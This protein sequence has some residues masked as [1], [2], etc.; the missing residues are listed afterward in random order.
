MHNSVRIAVDSARDQDP[1]R[2]E[3][4]GGC[5]DAC[6]QYLRTAQVPVCAARARVQR[7]CMHAPHSRRAHLAGGHWTPLCQG[8]HHD[9]LEAARA[10][11]CCTA[12]P[13]PCRLEPDVE[14]QSSY[15]SQSLALDSLS[16]DADSGA[17]A[18]ELRRGFV[19]TSTKFQKRQCAPLHARTRGRKV[20]RASS[21]NHA[22]VVVGLVLLGLTSP[23]YS[24]PALSVVR[25][26]EQ[27]TCF[28]PLQ[29]A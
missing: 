14:K 22:R 15:V 20:N 21:V 8:A 3:V 9:G 19:P 26:S 2:E 27:C 11:T 24:Y 23:W 5:A 16:S 29:S 13:L 17:H 18:C 6:T 4:S 25:S 7:A 1:M 28:V 10:A 12:L